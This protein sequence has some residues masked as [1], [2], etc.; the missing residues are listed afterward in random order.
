MLEIIAI[1]WGSESQPNETQQDVI[2][3][4][5][6]WRACMAA[7]RLLAQKSIGSACVKLYLGRICLAKLVFKPLNCICPVEPLSRVYSAKPAYPHRKK[8]I[9]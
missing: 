7:Q 1:S 4:E 3:A 8:T 9:Q 2:R 6:F 5:G